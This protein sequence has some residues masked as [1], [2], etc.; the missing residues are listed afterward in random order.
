MHD[1]LTVAEIELR[2][3]RDELQRVEERFTELCS[4][5]FFRNEGVGKDLLKQT[6]KMN[7]LERTTKEKDVQ[8][9]HLQV[10]VVR[11]F[12]VVHVDV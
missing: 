9:E 2:M 10:A 11:R 4:A 5:P 1:R 8:I 12:D 3:A 6:E 7:H